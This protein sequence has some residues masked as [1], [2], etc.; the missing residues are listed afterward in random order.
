M[1]AKLLTKRLTRS[2]DQSVTI[3]GGNRNLVVNGDFRDGT[4]GWL[5]NGTSTLSVTNRQLTINRNGGGYADQGYQ[6]IPTEIGETYRFSATLIETSDGLN[7]ANAPLVF[8]NWAGESFDFV[9]T[10]TTTRL[11]FANINSLTAFTTVSNVSV[12]KL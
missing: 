9:A 1:T 6:D 12:V 2:V 7:L 4:N 10:G 5:G 8:N 3:P 11:S